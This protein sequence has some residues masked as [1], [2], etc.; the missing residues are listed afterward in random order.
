MPLYR[1][2]PRHVEVLRGEP[3]YPLQVLLEGLGWPLSG[4]SAAALPEA[5]AQVLEGSDEPEARPL[6]SRVLSGAGLRPA[7]DELKAQILTLQV[8]RATRP[9]IFCTFHYFPAHQNSTS[10]L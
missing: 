3:S 9:C 8:V 5:V 1:G 4:P 10:D 6:E 7:H 2:L